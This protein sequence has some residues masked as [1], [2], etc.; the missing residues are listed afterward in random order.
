MVILEIVL[1]PINRLDSLVQEVCMT[2]GS[3]L[4]DTFCLNDKAIIAW[5]AST[6][7]VF[8]WL[9]LNFDFGNSES[10]YCTTRWNY[11]YG[12]LEYDEVLRNNYFT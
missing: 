9:V 5:V 1:G 6:R 2:T 4:M 12:L 10:C 3:D 7:G 11:R 8:Q